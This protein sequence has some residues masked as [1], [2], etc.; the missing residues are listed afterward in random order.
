M[1]LSKEQ[2]VSQLSTLLVLVPVWQQT[3]SGEQSMC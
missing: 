1:G 2:S 3:S